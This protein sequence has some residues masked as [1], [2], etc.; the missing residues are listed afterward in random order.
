MNKVILNWQSPL[1]EGDQEVMRRSGRDES[2]L[3]SI[4]KCMVTKLGISV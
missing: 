4:H 2:M 1:W 3:V